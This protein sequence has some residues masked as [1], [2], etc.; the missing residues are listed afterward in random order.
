MLGVTLMVV[1]LMGAFA[2]F[3]GLLHFTDGVVRR[4]R[5]LPGA[6]H[7]RTPAPRPRPYR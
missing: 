5:P 6:N 7:A 2:V 1:V 3:Y 4:G